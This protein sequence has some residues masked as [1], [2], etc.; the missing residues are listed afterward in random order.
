MKNMSSRR[1]EGLPMNMII[2]AILGLLV[3]IVVGFIFRESIR[4][5][6]TQYR[7]TAT[8]AVDESGGNDCG[9]FGRVCAKGPPQ[10]YKIKSAPLTGWKDCK[11]QGYQCYEPN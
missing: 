11:D 10:G 3:L 6:I 2:I 5:S 1:A 7:K 4:E 8:N 9:V